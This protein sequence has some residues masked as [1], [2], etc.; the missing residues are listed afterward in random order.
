MPYSPGQERI[1]I[2]LYINIDDLLRNTLLWKLVLKIP[3]GACLRNFSILFLINVGVGIK[4][5]DINRIKYS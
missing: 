1:Y 2:P 4:L 3:D 5:C